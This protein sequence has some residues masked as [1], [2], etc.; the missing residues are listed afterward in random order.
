VSNPETS[1]YLPCITKVPFDNNYFLLVVSPRAREF[2]DSGA[3]SINTD[4][5]FTPVNGARGWFVALFFLPFGVGLFASICV[6]IAMVHFISVRKKAENAP[7]NLDAKI[8]S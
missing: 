8:S 6:A 1:C 7:V 3:G 4:F 5:A 2:V